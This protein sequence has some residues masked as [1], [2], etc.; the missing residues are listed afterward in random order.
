MALTTKG[1]VNQIYSK[2]NVT[3][4]GQAKCHSIWT[5]QTSL[6]NSTLSNAKH[7]AKCHSERVSSKCHFYMDE[8][9]ITQQYPGKCYSKRASLRLLKKGKLKVTQKGQ[10]KGYSKRASQ[11]SLN[12]DKVNITQ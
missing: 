4:K 6:N 1:C 7:N 2:P 11:M 9:I 8:L 5:S 3:Q 10:V 12:I